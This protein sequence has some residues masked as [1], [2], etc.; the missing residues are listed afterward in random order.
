[1]KFTLNLPFYQVFILLLR[2]TLNVE[3]VVYIITNCPPLPL[4]ASTLSFAWSIALYVEIKWFYPV[5]SSRIS[6]ALKLTR[7]IQL[8]SVTIAPCMV[9]G[10]KVFSDSRSIF[11]SVRVALF[12]SG[13]G[14]CPPCLI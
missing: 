6:I 9:H 13:G 7:F 1:M 3:F 14:V 8:Y 11:T 12:W 2:L 10:Y 4:I 5:S